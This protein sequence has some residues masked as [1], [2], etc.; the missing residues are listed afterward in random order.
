MKT[1]SKMKKFNEDYEKLLTFITSHREL[2]P[3][4]IKD[5]LILESV[6]KDLS[7]EEKQDI[8]K[9]I[10]IWFGDESDDDEAKRALMTLVPIIYGD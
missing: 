5:K 6:Y 1:P 9:M 2:T 10:K 3:E 8:L 4:Q 7:D